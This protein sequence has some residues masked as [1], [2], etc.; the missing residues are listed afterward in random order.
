MVEVGE[1]LLCVVEKINGTVVFVRMPNEKEGSIILS[2]IAP[3]RIR[4]LRDYVFPGKNIVCKV[5]RVNGERV[6]LSL[7][8]VTLKE[9]KE[10]RESLSLEKSLTSIL[11]SVLKEKAQEIIQ[12]IKEE[13]ELPEFFESSKKDD[14]KLISLVGEEDSKKILEIL[15]SQKKKTAVVKKNFSLHSFAPNGIMLIKKMLSEFQE[16]DIKYVAAGKYL[17]SCEATDKK[18]ADN[19]IK[20]VLDKIQEKSKKE[21]FEFSIKEK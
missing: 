12:K 3:G 14:S 17:I 9:T 10:L 8:R 4:N 7:R 11:K 13:D 5:L 21:N 20:E 15:N 6:D 1:I 2:E 18:N 16:V 19:K